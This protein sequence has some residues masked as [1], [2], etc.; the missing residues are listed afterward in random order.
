MVRPASSSGPSGAG[1]EGGGREL[2]GSISDAFYGC[3]EKRVPL[4]GAALVRW[5]LTVVAFFGTTLVVLVVEVAFFWTGS[6]R[7][8]SVLPVRAAAA[9]AAAKRREK[10]EHFSRVTL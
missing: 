8:L 1:G 2:S 7:G 9:A 3:G 10:P 4:P 6:T 5:P